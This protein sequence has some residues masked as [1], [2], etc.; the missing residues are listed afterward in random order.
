MNSVFTTT[1]PENDLPSSS[2]EI[3]FTVGAT[4]A[5]AISLEQH[6]AFACVEVF[7]VVFMS[8][9]ACSD[10]RS[11]GMELHQSPRRVVTGDPG[12]APTSIQVA[13]RSAK[14]QPLF[15]R[16]HQQ[17]TAKVDGGATEGSIPTPRWPR[18]MR[19]WRD[20]E[21]LRRVGKS[22]R[23]RSRCHREIFEEGSGSCSNAPA[24]STNFRDASRHGTRRTG[25][26]FAADGESTPSGARRSLPRVADGIRPRVRICGRDLAGVDHVGAGSCQVGST[27][28]IRTC[29]AAHGGSVSWQSNG[30]PHRRSRRQAKVSRRRRALNLSPI[31]RCLRCEARYGFRGVR[32]GEALHPGPALRPLRRS[33][34]LQALQVFPLSWIRHHLRVCW[35]F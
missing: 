16:H 35:M 28:G 5:Q 11:Q 21:G 23:P 8:T 9:T 12:T 10:G 30:C 26:E 33:V 15:R 32:V 13:S 2:I 6:I 31:G 22:G 19:K 34:R 25:R 4:L 29:P 17:Q 27:E 18:H 1:L 20:A 7:V 24:S 14:R 3:T